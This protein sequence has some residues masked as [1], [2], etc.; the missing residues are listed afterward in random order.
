[1]F[2]ESDLGPVEIGS[3]A[4]AAQVERILNWWLKQKSTRVP[5]GYKKED[6][7][8]DTVIRM[9]RWPSNKCA[10]STAVCNCAHWSVLAW[11]RKRTQIKQ[12]RPILFSEIEER[13]YCNGR[14]TFKGPESPPPSRGVDIAELATRAIKEI[15][16]AP[17]STL[18]RQVTIALHRSLVE[19]KTQKQI[20]EEL[21]VSVKA[22]R[23]YVRRGVEYLKG[24][25]PDS[26][27]EI[28]GS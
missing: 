6:L 11:I 10:L 1:M 12:K 19:G 3:D 25:L 23:S 24:K 14:L 27:E 5:K 2:I 4:W 16:S 7:L 9:L 8:Q 26:S 15:Y 22:V 17:G 28:L 20:A 13:R 21:G 18:S